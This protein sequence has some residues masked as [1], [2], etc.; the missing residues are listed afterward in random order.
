MATSFESAQA[1]AGVTTTPAYVPLSGRAAGNGGGGL[2]AGSNGTAVPQTGTTPAVAA[3][4]PTSVGNAP[5]TAAAAT[6][7]NSSFTGLCE[8]LNTYQQGRVTA[9]KQKVADIYEIKFAPA[10]MAASTIKKP[11]STNFSATALQA[12]DA[13]G[14][15]L[16]P[17]TNS[18][19]TSS[20]SEKI[21]AGTQIVQ[22]IDKV[23]RNSSYISDQALY[24]TDEVTGKQVPNANNAT[25]QMAWFKI[26]VTAVP[27]AWDSIR[28]DF[29]YRMIYTISTYAITQMQSEYFPTSRFRG[30]HKVYNYWFTGQNTQV[31]DFSQDYNNL[32]RWVLSG[33]QIKNQETTTSDPRNIT[34]RTVM[35]ASAQSSQG[36]D[37]QANE[38]AANAA[39]YLYSPSDQAS[40]KLKIVGDP[41]WLQ[42]GEVTTGVSAKNFN[43]APFNA[44]GTINYEAS[45]ITFSIGWNQPVDY[46]FDTGIMNVSANNVSGTAALGVAASS[47]PQN[48]YAY[49]AQTVR[50]TFS[51]GKF[52]QELEGKLLT[53]EY[54]DLQ[55][56]AASATVAPAPVTAAPGTPNQAAT[57][58]IVPAIPATL[59]SI[60]TGQDN[61]L[62]TAGGMDF[63]QF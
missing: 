55:A 5:P 8:A 52:E 7:V 28:N 48:T 10:S 1:A 36:A 54:K 33:S 39:D 58:A 9:G 43:F 21:Q 19:D 18:V 11:G 23:M 15:S 17:A 22:F 47:G 34:R 45:E 32:Y 59:S 25:G 35:V 12:K 24:I 63:S 13:N 49:V 26:N 29:G 20:R 42:Q 6:K 46:N 62:A 16:A 4:P 14:R 2:L 38:A 61:P 40:V 30:L 31:L 27:L 51:K 44:D 53:E 56:T 41:A 3:A 37:K 60:A 57:A 50:S